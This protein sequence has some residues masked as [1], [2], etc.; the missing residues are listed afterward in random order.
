MKVSGYNKKEDQ[1]WSKKLN[2]KCE[3]IVFLIIAVQSLDYHS[4]QVIVTP[5]L[6][7]EKEIALFITN[8]KE[9]LQDYKEIPFV[10]QLL[11][12]R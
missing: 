10:K 1:F 12:I 7:K 2:W 6:G 3:C 5:V 8:F 9:A 4:S 11:E